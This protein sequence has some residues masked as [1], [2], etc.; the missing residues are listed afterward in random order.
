MPFLIAAMLLAGCASAEVEEV[1]E[2]S[3]EVISDE[4][5]GRVKGEFQEYMKLNY[6]TT[7]WLKNLQ[8]FGIRNSEDGLILGIVTSGREDY[9]DLEMPIVL[10]ITNESPLEI[11]ELHF[12][13]D[14]KLV[15]K[16]KFN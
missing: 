1:R 7:S 12:Y 2:V 16:R 3:A 13:H 9:K 5:I 11:R 4:E 15:Q 6:D 14:D 10:W 8:G